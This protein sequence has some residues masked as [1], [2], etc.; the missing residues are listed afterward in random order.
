MGE[1][2]SGRR[3][4]RKPMIIALIRPAPTINPRNRFKM[5]G[6]TL[7]GN[8]RESVCVEGSIADDSVNSGWSVRTDRGIAVQSAHNIAMMYG[9][10]ITSASTLKSAI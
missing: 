1:A 6:S 8:A 3:E 5:N 7:E 10:R 2:D 4:S 9:M